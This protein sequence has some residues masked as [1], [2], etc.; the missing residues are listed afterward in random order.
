M[1][2]FQA[3]GMTGKF[4][5]FIMQLFLDRNVDLV[6]RLATTAIDS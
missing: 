6:A 1:D 2:L 3:V 5:E 4:F